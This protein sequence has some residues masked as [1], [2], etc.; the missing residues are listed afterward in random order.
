MPTAAAIPR[1][2]I[3]SSGI[4]MKPAYSAM[5]PPPAGSRLVRPGRTSGD[6]RVLLFTARILPHPMGP[7]PHGRAGLVA[8]LLPAARHRLRRHHPRR[9]QAGAVLALRHSRDD[10]LGHWR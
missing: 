9:T 3:V 1:E 7:D 8:D 4:F 5:L 2:T 6:A 10:R